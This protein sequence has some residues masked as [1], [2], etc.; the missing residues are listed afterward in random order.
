MPI[1]SK[2]KI[3]EFPKPIMT[4]LNINITCIYSYLKTNEQAESEDPIQGKLT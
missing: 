3:N 2:I 4:Q 1:R